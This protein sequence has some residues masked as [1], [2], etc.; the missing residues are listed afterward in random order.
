MI[1]NTKNI[2]IY[3]VGG[4]VRDRLLNIESND[5]DYVI[6]GLKDFDEL[7]KL[8]S[9]MLNCRIVVET[10]NYGV[11]RAIHPRLGGVDF[12][13]PRLD[14]EENGRQSK[15]KFVQTIE[16]DLARRDFT[17][18]AI[19]IEVNHN[20]DIK[21]IMID[22]F[23]GQRDIKNKVIRFVGDPISRVN[24]DELRVLRAFRFAITKNFAID[25]SYTKNICSFTI[26]SIVS[27]ERIFAE[28][29]KML[30]VSNSK[31]VEMLIKYNHLYL[32]DRIKLKAST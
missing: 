11:I 29:N 14:F 7:K 30:T 28:I 18:N 31:T 13:L 12:A 4:A 24:E 27:N 2:K 17:M 23:D 10:P 1:E 6:T 21:D 26:S 32:L 19:A 16:E 20:L 3:L 5:L 15:V 22:P 9:G 8:V 25:D